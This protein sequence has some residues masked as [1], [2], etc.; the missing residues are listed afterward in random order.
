M[1]E[2]NTRY[3]IASVCIEL[4]LLASPASLTSCFGSTGFTARGG[5]PVVGAV[6]GAVVGWYW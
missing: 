5:L 6:G 2:R 4:M 1:R 3:C